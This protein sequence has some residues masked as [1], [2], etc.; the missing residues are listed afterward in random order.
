MQD[1]NDLPICQSCSLPLQKNLDFGTN[2]DGSKNEEYCAY[3]F[4]GGKFVE[5]ELRKEEMISRVTDFMMETEPGDKDMIHLAVSRRINN[6]R[7]WQ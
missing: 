1:L 4:K 6:L 7:R 3:C 5:P 2:A